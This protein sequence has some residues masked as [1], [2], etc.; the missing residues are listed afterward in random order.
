MPTPYNLRLIMKKAWVEARYMAYR[1][2][3]TTKRFMAEAL[4][5]A[6]AWAKK[7]RTDTEAAEIQAMQGRVLAALDEARATGL[8]NARPATIYS[9]TPWQGSFTATA[10]YA[11]RMARAARRPQD[12]RGALAGM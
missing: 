9:T 12:G 4:R 1:Q 8:L 11:E 3:G 7:A 10:A 6:W 2:G 5:K